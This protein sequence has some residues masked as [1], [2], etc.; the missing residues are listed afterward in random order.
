MGGI[1]ITDTHGQ[2]CTRVKVETFAQLA[3]EW[4]LELPSANKHEGLPPLD[5]IEIR[6]KS[7]SSNVVKAV[8]CLQVGWLVIQCIERRRQGLSITTLEIVTIAYSVN[9][10][11]VYSLWWKKPLDIQIPIRVKAGKVPTGKPRIRNWT[12]GDIDTFALSGLGKRDR[13]AP[14]TFRRVEVLLLRFFSVTGEGGVSV[15]LLTTTTA[16]GVIHVAAWN[17]DF[18]SRAEELLWRASSVMTSALPILIFATLIGSDFIDDGIVEGAF[19]ILST[20]LMVAYGIC[21]SYLMVEP[22]VGLRSLPADAYDAV[23]WANFI[24]HIF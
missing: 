20:V 24:P 6:D 14:S 17:S 9:A 18:A 2:N 11:L 15:A 4:D 1:A 7:K 12:S 16:F 22:F 5:L 23:Q 13:N 8:A 10:F 21:R 19:P 3:R